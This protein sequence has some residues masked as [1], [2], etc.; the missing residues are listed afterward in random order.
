VRAGRARSW[1]A[2]AVV[3][4]VV[5]LVTIVLALPGCG[6]GSSRLGRIIGL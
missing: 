3:V 2:P 4:G 1:I 6:S 5:V